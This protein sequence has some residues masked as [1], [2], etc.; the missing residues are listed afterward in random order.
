MQRHINDPF[1]KRA[2]KEGYVSRA[3][4]KLLA[5]QEKDKILKSGM[6]ILDL[7]AAP[8]GW[9][10][11]AY[12]VIGDQGKIVAVDL[13]PLEISLPITFIQG[14]FADTA[15][16]E[17]ITQALEHQKADMIISDLLPNLS[18]QKSVDI[19]KS[20]YL[21]ELALD[22]AGLF[23]K[24]GGGFLFKA[25]QGAGFEAFIRDVKCHFK[26]VKFRKPEASRAESREVYVL[27]Q[28]FQPSIMKSSD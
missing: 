18:G 4:Y 19:P 12:S 21:L 11:V 9:S 23:L 15:I 27:A 2:K 13:L 25:F 16:I 6:T 5:I 24:P 22:C 17:K 28:D 7:G 10:Q 3:A 20:I 1:V 26:T 14:D 8:G